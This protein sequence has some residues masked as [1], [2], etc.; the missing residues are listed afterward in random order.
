MSTFLAASLPSSWLGEF[1][2]GSVLFLA[3]W[4]K[5]QI[6]ALVLLGIV[7]VA[8]TW[9]D[10]RE[11]TRLRRVTLT[12]LRAAALTLAVLLVLEPA[13]ELKHVSLVKNHVAVLVDM[14]ESESLET[15]TGDTRHARALE[16]LDALGPLLNTPHEQ[17]VFD[18]YAVSDLL[19]PSDLE[20]L[21]QAGQAGADGRAGPRG[22]STHILEAMRSVVAQHGARD[23]GGFVVISDG[24]DNGE[25]GSRVMRGEPLDAETL[26]FVS[27]LGVPV[28]TVATA[29]A[30]EIRDV[31][32]TRVVRDDFAFVRNAVAV[33]AELE[34]LGV[35]ES[36]ITVTLRREGEVLQSR[37]LMLE[38]GRTRYA[39]EFEFVP[40]LI[41]KEI[42]A[43][44]TPVLAGEALEDN[45]R[46]LFVLNVIRDKIRVLQ[47]VGRPSWD[48]RFMRQLLQ[49]NP[50]VELICFF[51]LRT[52][53]DIH[54]GTERE[55]SLIPFPTRELFNE[56]LGSFDLVVFQ[57]FNYGP[58]DMRQYLP[59]IRE[60]VEGGG[61][62]VMIGGDL[63]FQSGDY[64]LTDV[65]DILPVELPAGR[66]ESTLI[67]TASFRPQL[68]EAGQR[69][70]ITRL[71]FD[72][73]DN[74][75]LWETL[76]PMRG[77][78]RV[79]QARDNAVVLATHPTLMAGDAPMPTVAVS[80]V[81]EG[82]T[83]A[84]TYDSSWRWNFEHVNRGGVSAPYTSFW[85]SAVRW[86]I[87]DP[88]LNLVD[89]ELPNEVVEPGATVSGTV[90]VFTP[91]YAPAA[92]TELTLTVSR[93]ALDDL[94]AAE[95]EVVSQDVF[96]TNDRGSARLELVHPEPG[97][98]VVRATVVQDDG[99]VLEDSEVF[100]RVRRSR[101]LRD[102]E[103]RPAL[104][105]ALSTASEGRHFARA[106]RVRGL[107]FREARVEEVN[108]RQ[109]LDLWNVPWVLAVF[110]GLLASEWTLRRRW[111]RL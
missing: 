84:V 50:N 8:L 31:S 63:S 13:L 103:P 79:L 90:R 54:R 20:T 3:D 12:G 89:V 42:Y 23:L 108:R 109:V 95:P 87:R 99:Q 77:T 55:L 104:L 64:A 67:D 74:R 102:V 107:T 51:I 85:N 75:A 11:M 110:L 14:S 57:N 88:E 48:V 19:E 73:A 17:H 46:E 82:R 26:E 81:G 44:E 47:V 76:P 93:R 2:R 24:I 86:L 6:A 35:T 10:V 33:T 56:E 52:Q 105:E 21:E 16:A 69:H 101:E 72:A 66:D 27:G 37:Q 65:G 36:S 7:V 22:D 62:F 30:G 45:N 106:D 41:G 28:H 91:E 71:A 92:N 5:W 9:F 98:Y 34:V 68:T 61:G 58:Y 29:Q 78:N 80:E 96:R 59:R 43:V 4:A 60:Y 15:G 18:V 25:L 70:P 83:M 1:N 111:G 39:V 53:D 38:P 32:V 100:L 49:N 40:E 97:A 94:A